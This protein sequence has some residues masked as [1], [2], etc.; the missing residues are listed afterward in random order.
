MTPYDIL[1]V[2][3]KK[4]YQKTTYENIHACYEND[5]HYRIKPKSQITLT[6]GFVHFVI[7]KP[8]E[9][10]QQNFKLEEDVTV[11]NET[12]Q[13]IYFYVID[14]LLSSTEVELKLYVKT[15]VLS[16]EEEWKL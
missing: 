4:P 3:K 6:P 15:G 12:L 11:V 14:S 8:K 16:E 1:Q 10:V 7:K 13:I 5:K 9:W 2:W